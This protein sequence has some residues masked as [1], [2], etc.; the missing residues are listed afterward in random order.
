MTHIGFREISDFKR[1]AKECI[2][3]FRGLAV[4]NIAD[5]MNRIYC[6]DAAIKPY[7]QA[8][9][10]GCAFTVKLPVGDNLMFHR[11][12]DLAK[13]GDIIVVDGAGAM[14]RSLC[15]E[16]MVRYAMSRDIGGFLLDGSIRD[17]AEIKKIIKFPVFARGVTPQGPFKNGPGEINVPVCIG[18]IAVLPGDILVGDEDGVVVVR[19]EDAV[20]VAKMAQHHHDGEKVTFEQIQS[21]CFDHSWVQSSLASKN[22]SI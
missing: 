13:P 2:E 18:G 5:T 21:G 22:Y 1:P 11:A 10:L 3:L 14:E 4:S 7:S 19:Q 16:I 9:L 6:V 17:V 12:L 20:Q 15:G 8:Q